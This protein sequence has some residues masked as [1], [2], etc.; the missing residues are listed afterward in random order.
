MRRLHRVALLAAST[1]LLGLS[2]MSGVAASEQCAV[3]VRPA[4][5]PPAH[6]AHPASPTAHNAEPSPEREYIDMMIPHHVS[7]IALAETALPRLNDD[8]LRD[9]AAAI[10]ATQEAEIAELREMRA[11][12]FDSPD[13]VP[14]SGETRD[15]GH[16]MAATQPDLAQL[17]D[18]AALIDAYCQAAQPDLAFASLTLA[19]HQMAVDSSRDLLETT[20]DAELRDL[21]R[22]VIVA[23][24][25]EI[26]TLRQFLAEHGVASPT[27]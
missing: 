14:M 4:A 26:A 20:Q 6:N 21:A 13:P 7:I 1:T 23:Q 12:R 11:A 17:M 2:A 16:D 18:G 5:T 25:A 19:H 9:M 15:A 24:E 22:R 10:V 8:R 3:T 27:P